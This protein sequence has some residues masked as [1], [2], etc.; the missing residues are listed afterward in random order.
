MTWRMACVCAPER[1][2]FNLWRVSIVV[3]LA[4]CLALS[5]SGRSKTDVLVMTN[6]DR[7]TC[8]VKSLDAG[9][10]KVD[11]DYVDGTLSVDWLKVARLEST[12]EFLVQLQDGSVYS[13]TMVT[14]E[15]LQGPPV[16]IEV[17]TPGGSPRW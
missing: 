1:L 17:R 4:V 3:M 16:K 6:C 5:A 7:I 2:M 13:G 10:L 8:Q 14:S 9:V 11:L 15:A 12:F